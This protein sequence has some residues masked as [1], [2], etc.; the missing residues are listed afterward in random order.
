[1]AATKAWVVAV[2]AICVVCSVVGLTA[3]AVAPLWPHIAYTQNVNQYYVSYFTLGR[4]RGHSSVQYGTESGHYSHH[5]TGTTRSYHAPAGYCHDVLITDVSQ[6]VRYYYRAGND[7]DGWSEEYHFL[8]KISTGKPT[9]ADPVVVPIFGDMGITNSQYTIAA[10]QTIKNVDFFYHVGDI[11]YADDRHSDLYETV[12]NAWFHNM[13]HIH[14]YTPYMVLPGN[15]EAHSGKAVLEY[16]KKFNVFNYRF[17]MPSDNDYNM[18]Y[19]INYKNIHFVSISTETDYPGCEF[20]S[21]NFGNQLGWLEAD[22]AAAAAA[23]A[24]KERPWIIVSG[25][26]PLYSS[27]SDS[28]VQNMLIPLQ[29]AIE[30]MLHKYKVDI[31]FCGHVHAYERTYPV[32]RNQTV[33]RSYNNPQ[34]V[35]TITTGAAGD[36]EGIAKTWAPREWSAKIYDKTT[37]YGVLTVPS[38]TTLQWQFYNSEDR[39]LIDSMTITK[40]A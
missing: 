32:Y 28:Y 38:D 15:H 35:V 29:K 1:M 8:I 33:S 40:S 25:H 14:P 18:W 22:L 10:L 2:V 13:T 23:D 26:R 34:A 37:G 16:S 24:R 36:I 17:K 9:A 3:A 11:S 6:G 12:W 20:H 39:S 7:V 21:Y 19:S 27:E 4:P 5:S 31:F 30:E